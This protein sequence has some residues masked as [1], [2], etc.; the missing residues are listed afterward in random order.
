M[1]VNTVQMLD[2]FQKLFVPEINIHLIQPV[3]AAFSN[4]NFKIRCERGESEIGS[5][6]DA[7]KAKS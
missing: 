6:Y 3:T 4:S 7:H 2:F 1:K 5:I